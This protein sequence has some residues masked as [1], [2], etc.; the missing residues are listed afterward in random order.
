M[1]PLTE[2]HSE[3]LLP[4]LE[5]SDSDVPTSSPFPCY[6]NYERTTCCCLPAIATLP[7]HR[8]FLGHWEVSL[9]MPIV[10]YMLIFTSYVFAMLFIFPYF[11]GWW[12]LSILFSANFFLFAYCYARTIADGPGY[13]PFHYPVVRDPDR[14]LD[15]GAP[16]LGGSELSPS[17]IASTKEQAKWA[18]TRA[19]PNRCIFSSSA[20]RIVARPDHF[21][22]WTATWVGKRNHK[23]FFLFNVWGFLYLTTFVVFDGIRTF[24]EAS[25]EGPG[26]ILIGYL[27]Y[28]VLGIMFAIMTLTFVCSHGL[29]FLQNLTSWEEWN[30]V[31]YNRFDR[32]TIENLEDICGTRKK[33]YLWCCPV[34]PWVGASTVSLVA[35]YPPYHD[36]K[37]KQAESSA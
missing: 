4:D 20:R 30:R 7:N 14:I 28:L 24:E 29:G 31:Q 27:I 3:A 18:K 23:F 11:R 13:F 32:G 16:L 22:A 21:C 26:L 15:E 36:E 33:W 25:S 37:E 17:G 1:D 35:D 12:V 10:V 2:R 19:V 9:E 6:T 5:R 34:S 8:L